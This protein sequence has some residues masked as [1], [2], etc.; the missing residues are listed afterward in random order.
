[1]RRSF[2]ELKSRLEGPSD[3]FFPLWHSVLDDPR[4]AEP[5]P[6]CQGQVCKTGKMANQVSLVI[7]SSRLKPNLLHRRGSTRFFPLVS[8]DVCVLSR[9]LYPRPHLQVRGGPEDGVGPSPPPGRGTDLRP[10]PPAELDTPSSSSTTT[11][12][13]VPTHPA[14]HLPT[15]PSP[16]P[17]R[18]GSYRPRSGHRRLVES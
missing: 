4:T 3:S 12:G 6:S 9:H 2:W 7:W 17:T 18:R 15:G 16:I 8:T 11:P 13:G 1:M 5:I 14:R 10:C